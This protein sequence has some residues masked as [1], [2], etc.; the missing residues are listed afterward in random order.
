M[1]SETL[2]VWSDG[3]RARL[4]RRLRRFTSPDMID[5]LLQDALVRVLERGGLR[6]LAAPEAYL[7]RVA[8]NLAIDGIRRRHRQ[9]AVLLSLLATPV[10]TAPPAGEAL[11]L[12]KEALHALPERCRETVILHRFEGLTYS[13][14]AV[15]LEVSVKTVE[16]RMSQAL[17]ILRDLSSTTK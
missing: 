13:E 15:R 4:R 11:L 5:D 1:Q 10:E 7:F 2:V 12:L 14:I 9:E 17:V 6:D 3:V 8:R 16:A